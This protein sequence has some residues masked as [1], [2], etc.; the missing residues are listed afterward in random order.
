[1]KARNLGQYFLTN[2]KA[3]KKIIAALGLEENDTVIEIG[4]GEG[5]LTL[6]LIKTCSSIGC[7]V[8]AIEKDPLLAPR[9]MQ[10][11]VLENVKIIYG[12]ALK[13]LQPLCLKLHASC[14]KLTGNIPYYITGRLLRILSEMDRRPKLA[15]LMF[16]RE[17]AERICAEPPRMN[18]LAA[19]TQFWAKPEIIGR[20]SPADFAP[21]PQVESAIVKLTTQSSHP[22]GVRPLRLDCRIEARRILKDSSPPKADQNDAARYYKF[23]RILFKQPRKTVL[24]NL[25]SG[26]GDAEKIK[27]ILLK[28]GLTGSERPQD[29]ELELLIKLAREFAE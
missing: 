27:K 13:E 17:V 29:L 24:N 7:K 16:Q 3:I 15:V 1:M 21:K 19:I 10:R 5:A 18:L 23:V 26:F 4:P 2:K 14:L 8:I 6:P 20:L 11:E 9:G 22:E 25:K 28:H 12:D